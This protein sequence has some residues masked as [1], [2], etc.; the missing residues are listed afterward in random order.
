MSIA[1]TISI[2]HNCVI[3]WFDAKLSSHSTSLPSIP[4]IQLA[5]VGR[6]K[7][8]PHLPGYYWEALIHKDTFTSFGSRFKP[9]TF[10][11]IA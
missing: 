3:N 1:L 6:H 8:G 7:I 4:D 11:E 5:K 9:E 2:S 10:E